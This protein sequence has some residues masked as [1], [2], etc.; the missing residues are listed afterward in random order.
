[1]GFNHKAMSVKIIYNKYIGSSILNYLQKLTHQK[2]EKR[3]NFL[4]FYNKK[5]EDYK[6]KEE[7]FIPHTNASMI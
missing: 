1:M 6:K 4:F 2:E 7:I 3:R 5:K